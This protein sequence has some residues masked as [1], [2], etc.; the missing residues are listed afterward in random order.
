MNRT[1]LQTAVQPALALL[2]RCGPL[3]E[4]WNPAADVNIVLRPTHRA[5]H[6]IEA[7][8]GPAACKDLNGHSKIDHVI[9]ARRPPHNRK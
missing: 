7:L 3:V 5:I 8:D 9:P 4:A 2:C 6:R 1:Q